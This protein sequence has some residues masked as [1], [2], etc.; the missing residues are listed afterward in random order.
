MIKKL[1][2]AAYFSA[3]TF[4]IIMLVIFIKTYTDEGNK[5]TIRKAANITECPKSSDEVD[6]TANVIEQCDGNKECIYSQPFE[7]A[8]S[9]CINKH[10][11]E[12]SCQDSGI[13]KALYSSTNVIDKKTGNIETTIRCPGRI[14]KPANSV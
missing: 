6:V 9:G 5:I 7:K 13:F 10:K 8:V 11:V 12:W 2:L 3:F 1:S 14:F 4:I